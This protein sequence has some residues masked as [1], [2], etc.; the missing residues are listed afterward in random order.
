MI[1]T[2]SSDGLI[3]ALSNTAE[4]LT[5]YSAHELVGRPVTMILADQS[6]FDVPQMMK[7][8][9]DWGAWNGEILHRNR[10]GKTFKAGASLTQLTS[11]ESNSA[12]FLLLSVPQE[13]LVWDTANTALCEVLD[14]FRETA[15][16]LNNPLAVMM[17]FI[18][19]I[20]LDLRCEGEM[21]AD[22]ERLYTEV[23]RIV[24][25]VEKMHS[26]AV[27]LQEEQ[28]SSFGRAKRAETQPQARLTLPPA[29]NS[30]IPC[31]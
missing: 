21:R 20:L 25:I 5:G 7:A 15:H 31:L 17:G 26:Y 4:Q 8:A 6:I 16:E 18:Q 2:L 9:V 30:D 13:K 22:V 10:S 14:R 19:L 3:S 1:V 12:G 28:P 27:S 11:R 24:Q 23:K 29:I